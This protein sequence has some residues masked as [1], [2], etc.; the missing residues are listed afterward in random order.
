MST[1]PD[2][3]SRPTVA[4][5]TPNSHIAI[6]VMGRSSSPHPIALTRRRHDREPP[7]RSRDL[8]QA[9]TKQTTLK[10]VTP[11]PTPPPPRHPPPPGAAV[12]SARRRAGHGPAPTARVGLA[13]PCDG[14]DGSVITPPFRGKEAPVVGRRISERVIRAR[15]SCCRDL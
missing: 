7:A 10:T 8:S 5:L 12:S 14:R 4:G 11:T 2:S 3:S 9:T 15:R 6:Q 13:P 1:A